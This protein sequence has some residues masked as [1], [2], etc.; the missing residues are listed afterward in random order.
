MS[1]GGEDRARLAAQ[2]QGV[3]VTGPGGPCGR[4]KSITLSRG[5]CTKGDLIYRTKISANYNNIIL[6]II[7][8]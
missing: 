1:A 5:C 4:G 3:A 8:R 2:A 6:I 7:I